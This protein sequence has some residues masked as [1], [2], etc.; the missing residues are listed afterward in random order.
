LKKSNHK[1]IQF[2]D[3][4]RGAIVT[5]SGRSRLGCDLIA[6]HGSR[7]LV[8]GSNYSTLLAFSELSKKKIIIR[9]YMDKD[10]QILAV[11]NNSIIVTR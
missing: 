3:I 11:S 10:F 9:S 6:K 2:G 5:I 8:K 7:W 4:P 1:S